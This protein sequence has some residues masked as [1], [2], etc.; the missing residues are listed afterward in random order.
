MQCNSYGAFLVVL[1][2][3]DTIL[4]INVCH[5]Y[6]RNG[7]NFETGTLKLSGLYNYLTIR[8]GRCCNSCA[9][10]KYLVKNKPVYQPGG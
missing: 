2:Y 3:I 4:Q 9:T 5:C 10:G 6:N 7:Y 8:D 1:L